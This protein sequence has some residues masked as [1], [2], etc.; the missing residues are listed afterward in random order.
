MNLVKFDE[1]F[2]FNSLKTPFNGL[3]FST[4]GIGKRVDPRQMKMIF[5]FWH[6]HPKL[7]LMGI[8]H[9]T[10]GIGYV[11]LSNIN[12]STELNFC[13]FSE[14][15]KIYGIMAIHKVLMIFFKLLNAKRI[16]ITVYSEN[17]KMIAF[18]DRNPFGFVR[19]SNNNRKIFYELESADFKHVQDKR[20]NA[21]NELATSSTF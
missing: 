6:E 8:T 4:I 21:I 14:E 13:I 15:H 7:T 20:Q 11:M 18:M 10:E 5:Q 19:L 3:A 1:N 12:H 9:G 2:V 17:H 16:N